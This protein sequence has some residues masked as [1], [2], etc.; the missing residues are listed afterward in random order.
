MLIFHRP[1]NAE[2]DYINAMEFIRNS[3]FKN[4]TYHNIMPDMFEHIH[5]DDENANAI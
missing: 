3:Y 2:T 5:N 1:Y 4:G